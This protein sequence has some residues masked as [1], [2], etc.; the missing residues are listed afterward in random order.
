M[1]LSR[2]GTGPD[3][4]AHRVPQAACGNRPRMQ[5]EQGAAVMVQA[6]PLEQ[7]S[8]G[9]ISSPPSDACLPAAEE[10]AH[11]ERHCDDHLPG[12]WSTTLHPQEHS[13]TLSARLHHRPSPQP[14]YG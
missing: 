4:G 10:E 13:L 6:G 14:L 12:A 2:A 7:T 1:L 5:Q 11:R 9:D 8:D 3:S